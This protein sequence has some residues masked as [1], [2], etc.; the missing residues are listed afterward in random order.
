L[1]DINNFSGRN[2]K[3]CRQTEDADDDLSRLKAIPITETIFN[4]LSDPENYNHGTFHG[5]QPFLEQNLNLYK[6]R[7]AIDNQGKSNGIRIMYLKNKA[8]D[9]IIFAHAYSK[10]TNSS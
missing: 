3:V 7:Y 8:D 4:V 6:L 10:K 2:P 1:G 9:T 5:K